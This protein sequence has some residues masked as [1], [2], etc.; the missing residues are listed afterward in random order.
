M[1]AAAQL[2]RLYGFFNRLADGLFEDQHAGKQSEQSIQSFL[3]KVL[4][5]SGCAAA[6]VYRVEARRV[7]LVGSC[8]Y[9]EYMRQSLAEQ[10]ISESHLKNIIREKTAFCVTPAGKKMFSAVKA[11]R[12]AKLPVTHVSVFEH[13]QVVGVVELIGGLFLEDREQQKL[14][15]ERIG[16]YALFLL[17]C[18][19]EALAIRDERE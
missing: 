14:L 4:K 9:P 18:V 16:K 12:F 5:F 2:K 8:S 15:S 13:H 10:K 6:G 7:C 3:L 19:S 1:N 17:R 11:A